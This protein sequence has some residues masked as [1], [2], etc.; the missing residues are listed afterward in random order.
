MTGSIDQGFRLSPPQH[1]AWLLQRGGAASCAGLCAW[2]IEGDLDRPALGRALAETV[3]R[4]EILRTAFQIPAVLDVALQ[5]ILPPG[6]VSLP[7]ADLQGLAA[8]RQAAGLADLLSTLGDAPFDLERGSGW[9]AALVRLGPGEHALG[10]ALS[11]VCGDAGTFEPLA[12]A[13]FAAYACRVAGHREEAE[14]PLQYA[15]VAE[16]QNSLL[17]SE[18]TVEAVEG[19]REHWRRQDIGAR[20]AQALPLE[21]HETAPGP[22]TLREAALPLSRETTAALVPLAGLWGCPLPV[23]LLTAWAAVMQRSSGRNETVVGTLYGGR[24]AEELRDVI[25]PLARSLP[26]AVGF[27]PAVSFRDAVD[28]VREAVAEAER[29]GE[30][31]SWEHVAGDAGTGGFPIGFEAT[32]EGVE[33][34]VAGLRIA[35]SRLVWRSP[36]FDR[37]VL[38]LSCR[39]AGGELRLALR[40]DPRRFRREAA[41]ALAGRLA[42]LLGSIAARPE[43]PLADHP[44]M[45]EE[46]LRR[47]L[48]LSFAPPAAGRSREGKTLHAVFEEQADRTPDRLAVVAADGPLTF[49]ELDARANRLAH[50]LR[51]AG[52][53]PEVPVALCLERSAEAV[54][55]LLAVWKAGAAY[56]PLD[57]TQPTERLAWLLDDTG[58]PLLVTDSRLAAALPGEGDLPGVRTVRLDEEAEAIAARPAS[59]PAGGADPRS[60]AR[61][62]T[63]SPR[64]RRPCSIPWRQRARAPIPCGPA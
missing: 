62:S 44:A 3:A 6:P 4:H 10:L 41:Q 50:H 42:A 30:Y 9:R 46:E 53:G 52:A 24:D 17:E 63:C 32:E 22:F 20:I 13:L 55:A 49:R 56:V 36:V 14:P 12:A 43:A 37:C 34:A 16:W 35:P 47:W 19:W 60:L 31:F 26:V 28:Q 57:P 59:R 29:R 15:D 58:A 11:A 25:G 39:E 38:T 8:E 21:E 64:W 61:P 2:R 45:A 48:E 51:A 33:L 1:R 18:D 54:V 23:L 7:E 5:V 40:Y 27:G